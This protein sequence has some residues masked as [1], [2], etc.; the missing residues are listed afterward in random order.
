MPACSLPRRPVSAKLWQLLTP[1]AIAVVIG[2]QCWASLAAW[3][4]DI[5]P[6]DYIPAPSGTSLIAL[7][8]VFED[9]GPLNIARGPTITA[10]TGVR[11]QLEVLR[12]IYY[13]D[14]T[15]RSYA[16]QFVLP[17]GTAHGEIAGQEL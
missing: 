15:G 6:R 7:Y 9:Y 14:I 1:A 11:S 13:G 10:K 3:A 2:A 5:E 4:F 12:Y 16:L 8:S 17:A